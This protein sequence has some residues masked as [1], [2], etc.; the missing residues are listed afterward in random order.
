LAELGEATDRRFL[1]SALKSD[2]YVVR[3]EASETLWKTEGQ[4]VT[5][6]LQALVKGDFNEAVR[7]SAS[8]A[9]LRRELAGRNPSEKV[10]I[11]RNSLDGAERLTAL[12]ILRTVLDEAATEGRSFLESIAL[13]NDSLGERSRAYLVLADSKSQ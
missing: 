1:I 8:Q 9:L 12:W 3:Q 6:A 4:D 11:L 13:R 5:D 10:Q 2:D 7:D